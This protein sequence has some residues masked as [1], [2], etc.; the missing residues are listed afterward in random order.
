MLKSPQFTADLSVKRESRQVIVHGFHE[1]PNVSMLCLF[2]YSVLR[3]HMQP[4]SYPDWFPPMHHDSATI[5]LFSGSHFMESQVTAHHGDDLKKLLRNIL[6][7]FSEVG[8]WRDVPGAK[9]IC[10]GVYDFSQVLPQYQGRILLHDPP[11]FYWI[12]EGEII[13]D[14]RFW[15]VL[16]TL[17]MHI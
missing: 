17:S 3:I 12:S 9:M 7:V 13:G 10:G 6:R 15:C 11:L 2:S 14:G 4:L 8:S 1:R 5:E 16:P